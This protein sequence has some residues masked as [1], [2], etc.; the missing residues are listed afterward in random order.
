VNNLPDVKTESNNSVELPS[1]LVEKWKT[2]GRFDQEIAEL[3][4][5]FKRTGY[6]RAPRF[7]IIKWLTD[8]ITEF[9][10][11]VYRADTVKHT[12]E[13]VWQEFKKECDYAFAEWKKIILKKYWITT[14]F[15]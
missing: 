1:Q 12:E 3:D 5:F 15:I 8:Y 11:D 7:Y 13:Y 14:P 10:I 4:A 2:E 6:P 9:G